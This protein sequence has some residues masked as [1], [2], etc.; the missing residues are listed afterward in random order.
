MDRS[1]WWKTLS[2]EVEGR[3]KAEFAGSYIELGREAV[4]CGCKEA[5]LDINLFVFA[6]C[7]RHQL[8]CHYISDFRVCH[9]RSSVENLGLYSQMVCYACITIV[10]GPSL[11]HRHRPNFHKTF[12][13]AIDLPTYPFNHSLALPFDLTSERLFP[14]DNTEVET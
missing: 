3:K 10:E 12:G 6:N 5:E 13:L 1:P 9:F 7:M 8:A 11:L 4:C 2:F 14:I